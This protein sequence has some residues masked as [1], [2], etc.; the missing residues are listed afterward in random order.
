[1]A[2]MPHVRPP[3]RRDQL[4]SY[5]RE[6][7]KPR[8]AWRVGIEVEKMGLD[9]ATGRPIPY[10]A[11]GPSV[12]KVLT[13]LLGR[14]GGRP[15]FE[16][17]HLIGAEGS[18]GSLSLEPGGQ[19]EWSSRPATDLDALT[20]DLDGHLAAMRDV[21]A[22]LNVAWLDSALQPVTPVAQMPWMPKARY[23]IMREFMGA[24]GRLAHRM[25]TQTASI[26]CAFDFEDELDWTRKMRAGALLAPIAVA[27]FA[28]S[29]RADGA[30]TGY[31]SYRQ[32]IWRETEPSRCD[33]PDV[34][35]HPDFGIEAWVEWACSVP[36]I[37]L[38][39]D[40]GLVPSGGVPFGELL[41]GRGCDGAGLDDWELHLSTLFTE[42]RSYTYIEVRS[43]DL[44][45]DPLIASVPAFW[46]GILYHPRALDAALRLGDAWDSPAGWRAA[47]EAAARHGL[48]AEVAG[49]SLRAAASRAAGLATWGLE[50]GA[51]CAGTLGSGALALLASMRELVRT[52][53]AP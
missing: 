11:P 26:Q 51:A 22:A 53:T 33:L 40:N 9:A 36:T 48:D 44:Q 35:F 39:R 2:H 14:R 16:G 42:V 18:W 37:F 31:R 50:H 32:A 25:M 34:V 47:M 8:S 21:A 19:V 41:G 29:E 1:M 43:A 30:E 52:A 13:F 15:I 7:F 23:G 17:E 46:T 20:V 6:A 45:P 10:D 12:E 38:R 5:M 27:L 24:R 3:L 28:N 49:V 4:S